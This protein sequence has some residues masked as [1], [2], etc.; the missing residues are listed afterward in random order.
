[1]E[2][3]QDGLDDGQDC[4]KGTYILHVES[5]RSSNLT[6]KGERTYNLKVES[7]H[8]RIRLSDY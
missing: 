6:V 4:K 8:S 1:V 7:E 5:G 2:S 3:K